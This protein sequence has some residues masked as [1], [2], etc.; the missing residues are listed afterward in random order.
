MSGQDIVLRTVPIKLPFVPGS[1]DS[2]EFMRA[3][4]DL[5]ES[6][7]FNSQTM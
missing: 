3:V 7:V 6:K 4:A 1:R 2:L 5:G